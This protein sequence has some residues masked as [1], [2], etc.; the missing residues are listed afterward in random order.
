MAEG[1]RGLSAGRVQSVAL[2]MICDREE[3]INMFVQE[4]YWTLSAF[5]GIEGEKKNFEAKF[6]GDKK[7]KIEIKNKEELEQI[8]GKIEG[9]QVLL[10]DIKTGERTKKQPLPF[11]TSTLQQ[12]ASKAL[13][14][15]TSKTMSI[16]QQLYEGVDIKGKGT[17]GV[18]TYLRTDSTRISDEAEALAKEY[19]EK[20]YGKEY[21][22]ETK[23]SE[24]KKNK[25]QDAH[26]AIRPTDITLTPTVI[27]EALSRDQFR[28]YQLIWKR[29]TAS[30][31]TLA[32]YKTISAKFAI[33]DYIFTSAASKIH[34]DG[35]M[36]VYISS[37]EE[38]EENNEM[39]SKI[40]QTAKLF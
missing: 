19:I 29:F 39:L 30:Q 18:I 4:E 6:Y 14:F 7:K 3:E 36:S 23:R 32:R 15:S 22:G 33:G 11:T 20:N 12:E 16:A 24:N 28:L 26:E 34:F 35:F 9:K 25:V 17:I 40:S 2:R 31:M 37:D 5:L 38:K 8:K 13:N 1:K 27:K 10:D 21:I